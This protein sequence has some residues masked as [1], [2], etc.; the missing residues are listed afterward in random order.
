MPESAAEPAYRVVPNDSGGSMGNAI[1]RSEYVLLEAASRRPLLRCRLDYE[2]GRL[3]C[4]A[5]ISGGI[6]ARFTYDRASGRYQLHRSDSGE[7][8]VEEGSCRPHD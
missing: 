7:D 2:A 6:D 1:Q 5:P 3:D 4:A 8:P